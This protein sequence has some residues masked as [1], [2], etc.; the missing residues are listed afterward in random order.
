LIT[1][2]FEVWGSWWGLFTGY[3]VISLQSPFVR[4][5]MGEAGEGTTVEASVPF[6]TRPAEIPLPP[7]AV[8]GERAGHFAQGTGVGTGAQGLERL[9]IGGENLYREG[10]AKT[11]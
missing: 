9:M 2:F 3:L 5:Q 8:L 1:W 6:F 7:M 10:R 4:R 11:A